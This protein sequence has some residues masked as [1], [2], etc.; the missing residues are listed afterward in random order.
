MPFTRWA[1][2]MAEAARLG[3]AVVQIHYGQDAQHTYAVGTS[4]GGYQVRRRYF[5]GCGSPEPLKHFAARNPE[6]SGLRRFPI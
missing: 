1:A 3:R 2:F 6:L 4:N 5:R